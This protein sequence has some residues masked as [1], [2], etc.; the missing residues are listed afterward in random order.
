MAPGQ[1]KGRLRNP[2]LYEARAM[3]IL[4]LKVQ[5][6]YTHKQIAAQMNISVDTV[7]R[8]LTWA[9]R[10]GLTKQYENA[11][12]ERLVPK[13]V[14]I[15][16]QQ[17]DK[18]DPFVA[19]D[20]IDK[21]FK[22]GERFDR[23]EATQEGQT[24]HAYLAEKRLAM[25]AKAQGTHGTEGEHFSGFVSG[26]LDDIV[27]G[28]TTDDSN[29]APMGETRSEADFGPHDIGTNAGLPDSASALTRMGAVDSTDEGEDV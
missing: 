4:S 14:S 21:L 5:H 28:D 8:S 29:M 25:T 2:Q 17:L 20:I 3:Q 10:Q 12:I 19:K 13:A 6:G 16:E 24:L 7:E 9:A 23:R 27:S 26:H 15:Y 11:I 1:T 22:L 18:G